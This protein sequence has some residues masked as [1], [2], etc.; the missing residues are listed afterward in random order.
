MSQQKEKSNDRWVA[1][2]LDGAN[3]EIV[4]REVNI[5]RKF[6]DTRYVSPQNPYATL[7]KRRQPED[8]LNRDIFW[9][10]LL[11]RFLIFLHSMKTVTK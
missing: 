7:A 4:N 9:S 1:R 11:T 6:T 2:A 10:H 3:V 8:R 5:K